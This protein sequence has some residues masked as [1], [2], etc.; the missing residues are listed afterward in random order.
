MRWYEKMIETSK[1]FVRD[2]QSV[3]P[4][5]FM[6]SNQGKL[7]IVSLSVFGDNKDVMSQAMRWLVRRYDPA[8]YMFVTEAYVK[9]LDLKDKSEQALGSLLV[10]GTLAVSELPSS[11]EAIVV[12]YGTRK[13]E[14]L[15]FI[16]FQ[17]QGTA[18]TFAPMKWLSG[19]EAKGRF[20]HLRNASE[21]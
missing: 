3:S 18:V 14:R 7:E 8:E 12:L 5:F 19:D 9:M 20:M 1:S 13:E 16:R 10:K 4:V 6:K 21:K 11:Q 15:G 17:K 2:G